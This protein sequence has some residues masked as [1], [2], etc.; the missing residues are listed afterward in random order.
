[1]GKATRILCE[2]PT[3]DEMRQALV[4]AIPDIEEFDREAAIYWFARTIMAAS[5]RTSMLP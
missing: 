2:D 3:L 5:G 4:K 1:M